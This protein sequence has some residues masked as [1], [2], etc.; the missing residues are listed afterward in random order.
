MGDYLIS[1]V[2]SLCSASGSLMEVHRRSV[3]PE[4]EWLGSRLCLEISCLVLDRSLGWV[5]K[6]ID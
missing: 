5:R 1:L 3:G 6:L 2:W 4:I